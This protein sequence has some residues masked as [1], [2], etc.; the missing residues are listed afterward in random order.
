MFLLV[1][2]TEISLKGEM[3]SSGILLQENG[4]LLYSL[5][6]PFT[7]PPDR[8]KQMAYADGN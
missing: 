8:T 4:N 6:H 7:L 1:D 2:E 3:L 5:N